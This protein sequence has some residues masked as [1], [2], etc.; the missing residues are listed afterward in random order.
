MDMWADQVTR[1]AVAGELNE[2]VLALL[3]FEAA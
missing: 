1:P 3:L 2:L